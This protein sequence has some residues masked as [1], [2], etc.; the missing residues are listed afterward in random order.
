MNSLYDV[1]CAIRDDEGDHVSTMHACLDPTANLRSPS[2]E[3]KIFAGLVLAAAIG[4]YVSMG[5]VGTDVADVAGDAV[6]EN[7][8]AATGFMEPFLAGMAS[9][10]TTIAEIIGVAL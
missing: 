5:G 6:V 7:G 1:F 10:L 3:K 9:F 8:S 4:Y 2:R